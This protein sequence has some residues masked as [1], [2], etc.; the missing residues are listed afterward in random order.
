MDC[1]SCGEYARYKDFCG[2][3]MCDQCAEAED[4]A[5]EAAEKRNAYPET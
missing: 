4:A 3:W 1:E 2:H 5:A